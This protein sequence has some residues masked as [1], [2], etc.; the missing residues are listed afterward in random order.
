M[1]NLPGSAVSTGT[2]SVA[3]AAVR[4]LAAGWPPPAAWT[5]GGQPA[6]SGR[7][8]AVRM[9]DDVTLAVPA[10]LCRRCVRMLS[11]HLRDVPGVVS[12]RVEPARGRLS[13]TGAADPVALRAARDRA[14]FRAPDGP[15]VS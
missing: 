7:R 6:A 2:P 1:A 9:G 4:A 5:A 10:D 3:V 11:R 12:L 15:P 13:V 14:G 8:D